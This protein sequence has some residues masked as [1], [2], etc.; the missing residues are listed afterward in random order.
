MALPG[1]IFDES[2][3]V[4]KRKPYYLRRLEEMPVPELRVP[5]MS[6]QEPEV[7]GPPPPTTRDRLA[8]ELYRMNQPATTKQKVLGAAIPG[9][10]VALSGLFGGLEGASGAAGGFANLQQ[11]MEAARQKR[12]A[13]LE[14]FQQDAQ[15]RQDRID[16]VSL[17]RDMQRQQMEQ[18]ATQFEQGR[19]DRATESAADRAFQEKLQGM[20]QRPAA[21]Q[22]PQPFT[23]TPGQQRFDANGKPIANVPPVAATPRTITTNEGVFL[24]KPDGS[25]GAKLGERPQATSQPQQ[26]QV[27]QGTDTATGKPGFFVIDRSGGSARPVSGVGGP[28]AAVKPPTEGERKSFSFYGRISQSKDVIDSLEPEISKMGLGG[29]A[30]LRYAPNIAQSDIGQRYNQ[31][32]ADFINAALRRESGA[33]I[34]PSEYTRFNTIYFPQ[35]GDGAN[36]LKQK[37]QARDEVLRSL[38]SE[39]GSAY[40]ETFGE[41]A[42]GGISEALIKANMAANPGMSR[43]QVIAELSKP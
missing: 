37:A 22:A 31:A 26:P 29:Q 43:E 38:K 10:G 27:V 25:L 12:R 6:Q 21:I 36:V 23:L 3:A 19:T 17:A 32:A 35:P 40:R 30:Q 39:A 5:P 4:G 1:L 9:I 33:A 2:G 15:E 16:Q 13:Q 34:S 18:S 20:P 14:G 8:G 42:G 7:N 41:G 28:A 11:D 24:L